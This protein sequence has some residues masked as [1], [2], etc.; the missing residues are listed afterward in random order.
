MIISDLQ[1]IETAQNSEVEGGYNTSYAYVS[2]YSQAYG[3]Y[4]STSGN[5][6]AIAD[7]KNGVS[8]QGSSSSAYASY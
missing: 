7:A 4:T 2:Q 5:S 3:N 1:Y 8:L 6:Y